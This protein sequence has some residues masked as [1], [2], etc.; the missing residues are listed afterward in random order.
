MHDL[1]VID[2]AFLKLASVAFSSA[3]RHDVM[4][5]VPFEVWLQNAQGN[6][7]CIMA[8]RDQAET[9]SHHVE[10]AQAGGM[11]LRSLT[12]GNAGAQSCMLRTTTQTCGMF[13]SC[14]AMFMDLLKHTC[15]VFGRY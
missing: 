5:E 12:E 9:V 7:P 3:V 15:T 13:I 1:A 11:W 14:R 2:D 8:T 6:M 10:S 4:L